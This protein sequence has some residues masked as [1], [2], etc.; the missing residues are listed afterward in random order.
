MRTD[1]SKIQYNNI[2]TVNSNQM[3]MFKSNGGDGNVSQVS[4]S[5]F[6]GHSNAYSLYLNAHWASISPIAG[7]GILYNS[8]TFDNWTGDC[9]NGVQRAP[10]YVDCPS[11]N[12]CTNIAV[13]D[14][15]MWTD[16]GS[17]EYYKCANAW[18]NGYCLKAGSAHTSYATVTSTVTAAPSGY[19]AS[20]MPSDLKS[21][22]GISTSIAIPTVPTTFFPGATPKTKRAYDS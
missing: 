6:I 11:T 13:E 3:F 18:G 8:I 22:L 20:T 4:L 19:S 5:N 16:A 14:F 21:G 15:A 10:L 12:P 9:A 17:Q 1:I 7:D 2:Y